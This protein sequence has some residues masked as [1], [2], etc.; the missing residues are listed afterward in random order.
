M[1]GGKNRHSK[2]RMFITTTE[3]RNEYGGKK[4]AAKVENQALPFD[5]CALSMIPYETPCCTPEGVL[6]DFVNLVPFLR[7]HKANPVTGEKMTTQEII[8]LNMTKNSDG[9]WHCPVTCK[10]FTNNSHVVAIKT[11]GNVYSYEAVHE[12]NI[13]PKAY[14]DL[15]NGEVFKKTDIITLQN[16]NDPE[17]MALRDINNFKHLQ[18]LRLESGAAKAVE[19]QVI[20]INNLHLYDLPLHVISIAKLSV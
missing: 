3:W 10:V 5:Q 4:V 2:D 18:T 12:L 6:F 17:H 7:K 16:P 15:L 14:S 8:R 9:L 20:R 19:G 1:G 11:T 13:K